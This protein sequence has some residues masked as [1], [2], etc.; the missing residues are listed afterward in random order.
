MDVAEFAFTV[1][2]FLRP[3]PGETEGA[4]KGTEEFD[5]LSNVIVVFAVF[6]AGL[7]IKEVVASY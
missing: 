6:G 5:N 1:E 4:G 2:D 3:F 7:G